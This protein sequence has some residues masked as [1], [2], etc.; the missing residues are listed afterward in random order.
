MTL[1]TKQKVKCKE[2]ES[3]MPDERYCAAKEKEI[4]G[5]ASINLRYCSEFKADE[6][7]SVKDES[8]VEVPKKTEIK[9]ARITAQDYDEKCWPMFENGDSSYRTSLKLGYIS[10]NGSVLKSFGRWKA[11]KGNGIKEKTQNIAIIQKTFSLNI[12]LPTT[13]TLEDLLKMTP[14]GLELKIDFVRK[15]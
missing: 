3:Y 9:K 5:L 6:T 1:A 12:E 4:T 15:A 10:T 2:C 8:I 14:I 13:T 7:A 11:S